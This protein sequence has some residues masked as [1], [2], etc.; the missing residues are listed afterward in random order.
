MSKIP[1]VD[2]FG[3]DLGCVDSVKEAETDFPNDIVIYHSG[4]ITVYIND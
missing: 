1:V 4:K 3:N 2:N